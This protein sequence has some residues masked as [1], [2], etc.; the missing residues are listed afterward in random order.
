MAGQQFA[1]SND[2]DETT[3]EWIA[4]RQRIVDARNGV[5]R[6]EP[7]QPASPAEDLTELRRE[8]EALR[9]VVHAESQKNSWMAVPA[10]APAAVIM[11]IEGAG[12]IAARLAG[13][14]LKRL[15]LELIE[16][17]PFR[18]VGDNWATRAG[19]RA[20]DA[21]RDRLEGKPGWDYEP[22][23]VGKS[24]RTPKPDVGAPARNPAF[25]YKRRLMELKPDTPSGRAAAIRAARKYLGET[26]NKTRPIYYN[27]KDFL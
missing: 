4:R 15:P 26:G 11:G 10:L 17:E 2:R 14:Q 23:M 6:A 25:P 9:K 19:R 18:R 5:R 16:R 20:H 7:A 13:P 24:G 22:T 3:A 8:Q 1:R 27:P 21:L 12:A